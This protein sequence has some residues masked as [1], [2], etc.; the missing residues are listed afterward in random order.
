MP[1]Y[2]DTANRAELPLISTALISPAKQRHH[3][4]LLIQESNFSIG[5][6]KGG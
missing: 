2:S 5:E 3:G 1:I 6:V 4:N